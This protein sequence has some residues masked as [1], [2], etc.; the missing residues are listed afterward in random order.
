MLCSNG[1][2]R[3]IAGSTIPKIRNVSL[4]FVK[5]KLIVITSVSVIL[6]K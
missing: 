3:L 1:T 4:S 6:L 5:R 2:I